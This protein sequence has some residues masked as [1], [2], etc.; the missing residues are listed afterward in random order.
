MTDRRLSN[1]D[2]ILVIRNDGIGDL[3]NSTP[4]IALLRQNY[5]DS[6]ITVLAQPLNAPILVGNPDVDRVL[7]FDRAQRTS[8]AAGSITVLSEFTT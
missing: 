3:L 4:A 1:I 7:I 8:S 6:E 2:K 5:A